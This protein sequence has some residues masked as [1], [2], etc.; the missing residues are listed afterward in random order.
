MALVKID[1]VTLARRIEVMEN[2]LT[3]TLHAVSTALPTVKDDVINN[4]ERHAK[5]FEGKDDYIVTSTRAL[6]ARVQAFKP[7]IND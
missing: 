5:A 7:V 4:L 2:A 6:I 3:V 1:A